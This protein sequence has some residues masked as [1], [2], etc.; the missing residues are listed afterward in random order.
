VR[1]AA[2]FRASNLLFMPPKAASG[3]QRSGFP[4]GWHKCPSTS[5]GTSAA[6][7]TSWGHGQSSRW[8]FT[9]SLGPDTDGRSFFKAARSIGLQFW[10]NHRVGTQAR[11]TH[12]SRSMMGRAPVD[13]QDPAQRRA[14]LR[15]R[16]AVVLPLTLIKVLQLRS[17]GLALHW[18]PLHPPHRPEGSRHSAT[19][20]LCSTDMMGGP[21]TW[22]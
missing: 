5:A 21:M 2:G 3:A 20:P 9:P 4:A 6:S 11:S 16:P 22:I 10:S 13:A 14:Q 17:G 18:E 12:D 15:P 7:W 8:R 19:A 1:W